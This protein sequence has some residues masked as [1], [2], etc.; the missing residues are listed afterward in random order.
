MIKYGTNIEDRGATL[1][2]IINGYQ[3][4][5][6]LVVDSTDWVY[7]TTWMKDMGGAFQLD[8]D[9]CRERGYID[10]PRYVY[11]QEMPDYGLLKVFLGPETCAEFGG[12]VQYEDAHGFF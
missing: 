12:C 6:V 11:H 2:N 3:G 5:S 1:A 8:E 9:F 4:H 7:L 10:W